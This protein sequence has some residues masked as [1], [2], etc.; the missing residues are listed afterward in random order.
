M[1]SD[2]N[3][4]SLDTY[5]SDKPKMTRE[6]EDEYL[7]ADTII[8]MVSSWKI[9]GE[10]DDEDLQKLE[11]CLKKREQILEDYAPLQY[12][13][14]IGRSSKLGKPKMQEAEQRRYYDLEKRI[15]QITCWE[16]DDDVTDAEL[17]ERDELAKQ[18]QVML[19]SYVKPFPIVFVDNS[20][21]KPAA[22][23]DD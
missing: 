4:K 2:D 10:A 3:G 19:E 16:E 17:R 9:E 13:R 21:R 8:H 20:R 22:S 14:S 12:L 7:V 11:E 23:S 18:Q 5:P 6:V 15:K 1:A